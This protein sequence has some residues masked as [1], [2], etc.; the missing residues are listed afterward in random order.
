MGSKR[1]SPQAEFEKNWI[2]SLRDGRTSSTTIAKLPAGLI[3]F[4]AGTGIRDDLSIVTGYSHGSYRGA[5]QA[6]TI[7]T[8]PNASLRRIEPL[9]RAMQYLRNTV[10]HGVVVDMFLSRR[11]VFPSSV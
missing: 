1:I 5:D 7:A 9:I 10:L 4:R 6:P 11:A 3:V 8:A 2:N